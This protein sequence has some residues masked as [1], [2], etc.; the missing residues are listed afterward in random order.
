MMG[1]ADS[2]NINMSVEMDQILDL[3][4]LSGLGLD[5]LIQTAGGGGA[6][7]TQPLGNSSAFLLD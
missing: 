5:R 4:Q 7:F 1:F 2:V 3:L 6:S